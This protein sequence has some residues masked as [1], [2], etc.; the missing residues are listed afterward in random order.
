MK[1]LSTFILLSIG[2]IS[3]NAQIEQAA[4]G[5]QYSVQEYYN[6]ATGERATV[7][8]EDWDLAFTTSGLQDAGI[9]LNESASL[10]GSEIELYLAPK[11]NFDDNIDE[12]SLTERLYNDEQSWNTGA[13]NN[14]A[15]PMNPLDYGWGAYDPSA[16]SVIGSKVY[17]I[18]M[19]SGNFK[20]FMVES[21]A[22]TTYNIRYA[23]L[24]GSDEV[25]FSFDKMSFPNSDLAYFSF[26]RNEVFDL[27]DF[28][29]DIVFTR[30]ASFVLSPDGTDSLDY[31]ISGVLSGPGTE[32]AEAQGVDPSAINHHDYAGDYVTELDAIGYDWKEFSMETFAWN[33]FDDRAYFVK[34]A[35]GEIYKL[36]FIDFEGSSTGVITFEQTLVG[37]TSNEEIIIGNT[38]LSPAYPNPTN[39]SVT[40]EFDNQDQH[41]EAMLTIYN[42]LGQTI[43][44]QL[45]PLSNGNQ[46]LEFTIDAPTGEYFLHFRVGNNSLT[47]SV[48]KN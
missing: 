33:V 38:S 41:K 8:N 6:F 30:Y 48:I 10:D 19:R 28:D 25:T 37:T 31:V 1:I 11:S 42:K 7:A 5:P 47:Q 20:K 16:M 39:G 36:V 12:A 26:A 44:N 27:V 21:L 17:V 15:N 9:I 14:V 23:N 40:L 43:D 2:F 45:L 13:F 34:T 46:L 18:K 3:L 35:S 24:D 29:W 4:I 22:F 32:V